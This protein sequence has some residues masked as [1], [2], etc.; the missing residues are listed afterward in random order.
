MKNPRILETFTIVLGIIALFIVSPLH[1]HAEEAIT[2]ENGENSKQ[3]TD[4]KKVEVLNEEI[5]S[6]LTISENGQ[7]IYQKDLSTI[8][9]DS[10]ESV[11]VDGIEYAIISYRYDGSSNALFFE[12][13]RLDEMEITTTYTSDVYERARFQVED[14]EINISFPEYE[15]NDVKTDPSKIVS[16]S[17]VLKDNQV[18]G[19]TKIVDEIIKESTRAKLSAASDYKEYYT[20]PSNSE[21]SRILTEEALKAGIA[22]EIVKAIAYQESGWQ[23]FWTEVPES[24]KKCPNYDETNVKLGYDCNGI[25]I[26]QISNNSHRSEKDLNELKTNI[27]YNIQVGIEILKD[28]WGY[29]RSGLIPTINDNDPM[30]VENWYFAIMAYNALWPRNN[31]LERPFSPHGAYQEEVFELIEG[32]SLIDITPFPTH[33]LDPYV[34]ER[35]LLRFETSNFTVEG[36]QN[37]S[38]HML[39]TNDTAYVTE[40]SVNFRETPGGKVSGSVGKGDKITVTGK[41]VGNSNKSN[42]FVWMPVKTSSGK[43]GYI[44]SSYLK[45]TKYDYIDMYPLYGDLRYDTAVSVANFGWHWDQPDSV[46]IAQG[47]LPVD[48]LTGSVLASSLDAPILLNHSN[49]LTDSTKKELDRLQP[50]TIYILGGENAISSKV[51]SLLDKEFGTIIRI[52]GSNRYET[53]KKVANE[54]ISNQNINEVFVTTGDSDSSDSLAIAPYAG[55]KK[56]PILLTRKDRL[57]ADAKEFINN[58]NINK[59]TI[60]GG[61][62]AV[63]T[64]TEQQLKNLVGKSNVKRVSG[65]NR[66]DT[67]VEIVNT[68]YTEDTTAAKNNPQLVAFNNLIVAQGLNSADAL[69]AAPFASKIDAPIV[70]TRPDSVPDEIRSFLNKNIKKRPDLYILGGPAAITDTVRNQFKSLVK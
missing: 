6:K 3:L 63:S 2:F 11:N 48:A 70:L 10:M 18:T 58:N 22:P 56:I 34:D 50:K 4:T 57:D 19:G 37:Y 20:N 39:T 60:I 53:A 14:N 35:G 65:D 16:Q 68:Y 30:V 59:V 43:T 21:I 23:Q 62:S 29:H 55:E 36:P 31:P 32:F 8:K 49:K 28:K 64:K 54:V 47:S 24:I 33:K 41:F 40:N 67:S 27:R 46:I 15:E 7:V 13:L 51:E 9:V 26:M 5:T 17:F 69:A 1:S 38:S 12:V 42:H 25:G 45:S 61:T 44:A 52:S 66:Y